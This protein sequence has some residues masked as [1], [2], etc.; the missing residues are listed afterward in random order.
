MNHDLETIECL[1]QPEPLPEDTH[2]HEVDLSRP[3]HF[4]PVAFADL[5]LYIPT[6]TQGVIGADGGL[7]KAALNVHPDIPDDPEN[8]VKPNKGVLCILLPYL[9]QLA[10][11]FVQLF[12]GNTLNPVAFHTVTE[13]EAINGSQIVLFIPVLFL[14]EGIV[15]NVFF[16]VT[17]IGGGTDETKHFRLKVDT[18]EPGGPDPD[19]TTPVQ[20]ENLAKPIFPQHIIDIGVTPV[21]AGNG[22]KITIK[23]YPVNTSLPTAYS[24]QARDKIIIRLGNASVVHS[25]TEGEAAGTSIDVV[26][27]AGTWN[28]VDDGECPCQYT[29]VD[30]VG[31]YARGWSP[32]QLIYVNLKNSA[33]ALKRPFIHEVNDDGDLNI[34]DL[35]GHDATI[36]VY[37]RNL[38]YQVNDLIH[39]KAEARIQG[40]TIINYEYQYKVLTTARDASIPFPFEDVWPLGNSTLL[41]NYER[42]RAGMPVRR[43]E[44]EVINVIGTGSGSGLPP[45]IIDEAPDGNLPAD[46]LFVTVRI[47]AYP[48]QKSFDGI[49][50]RLIGTYANGA[51]YYRE[52][53]PRPAGTGN[54][55]TRIS[56]GPDGELAQLEGGTLDIQYVVTPENGGPDRISRAAHLEVGDIVASLPVPMVEEAPPPEFTFDPEQSPFGA[57]V[58]VR[59]N[60][61]F[62]LNSTVYLHCEG[63]APG[64][65]TLPQPFKITSTWLNR[66][67]YFDIDRRTVLANKD[68]T[69]RIYYT[70]IKEYERTR[71]SHALVMKVGTPLYPNPPEILESTS[72][73]INQATINPLHVVTPPVFTIRV[74][75]PMHAYDQI[76]A[77]FEGKQGLGTPTISAKLGNPV[78]NYVDFTITN[79]A[80]AA[81]LGETCSASFDVIRGGATT[82]SQKLIVN[83][84]PL[85][86]SS[87]DVVSIPEAVGGV[88]DARNY[89]SVL[90]QFIPFMRK[91]QEVWITLKG[92]T[93]YVLRDGVAV[94]SAEFTANRIVE[95][96]P[97]NYLNSL[98]NESNLHV[99][100]KVSLD[101]HG[102]IDTAIPLVTP[103]AYQIKK[104]TGIIAHIDVGGRP[105]WIAVSPDGNRIYVTNES[106]HTVSVINTNTD[107][108][109]HTITGLHLPSAIVVHPNGSTIYVS[110]LGAKTVSVI[111]ST[112]YEI[113]STIPGLNGPL[114][115]ALNKTGTRLYIAC[116]NDH[117]LYTHDTGT[118]QRLFSLGGCTNA[119]SAALNPSNSRLYVGTEKDVHL[120]DPVTSTRLSTYSGFNSPRDMAYSPYDT[121]SAPRL[122]IANTEGNSVIIFNAGSNIIHK[123]LTVETPYGI[124]FNPI[125]REAYVTDLRNSAVKIIDTVTETL[126]DSIPGFNHPVGLAVLPNGS[127]LYVANYGGHT[128]TVVAL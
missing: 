90:V 11:D 63:S 124:A 34:E 123:T 13:S 89:N 102:N 88:I 116:H 86:S 97:A 62:T 51:G 117:T 73:G 64:G 14:P 18:M 38:D 107:K 27:Y 26:V 48:G 80:I 101:G 84:Q 46:V 113:I 21:E 5:P 32:I 110:N 9:Q 19:I 25:L 35:Q 2:C 45:P 56:N 40:N 79:T 127:K 115:M 99:E 39:L 29:V 44:I 60:P 42:I 1:P 108:V 74:R 3:E 126:T 98:A 72:T 94:T 24:W 125:K 103:P 57:T 100:V 119:S 4:S 114:S 70:L 87:L 120:V 12:C 92:S 118:G 31:N 91:G 41:L 121:E 75:Y 43:S 95:D 83:V 112:S 109:I 15:D 96:I 82:S 66:D 68:L 33:P 61:A 58:I 65:S 47:S 71:F 81:N 23:K 37:I 106:S 22:I 55:V 54:F 78:L 52:I 122:Y 85:P 30:E 105:A 49:I 77:Y 93:D 10:G 7:N 53:G 20:N 28:Q 50:I 17:R 111:N 16:R 8:P 59:R 69:A 67:L 6:M 104:L 128:V 36:G 76:I